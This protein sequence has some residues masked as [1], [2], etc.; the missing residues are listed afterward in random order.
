MFHSLHPNLKIRISINFIQKLTQTAIFPFM[1]IYF[2]QQ[3]GVTLAGVLI[4]TTTVLSFIGSLYGG[5]WADRYGRKRVLVS[6]ERLGFLSL[7]GM[8]ICNSTFLSDPTLTFVF[9]LM[10]NIVN[11]IVT[12]A[13]EAILIDDSTTDNRKFLYALS[14]WT[15]NISIVVGSI[16]G[17]FL[18]QA[19]LFDLLIGA[20]LASLACMLMIR[21][22]LNDTYR[23]KPSTTPLSWRG[24]CHGYAI[25]FRDRLFTIY[26]I[27]GVLTLSLELQLTHYLAIHFVDTFTTPQ[28]LFGVSLDG[29]MLLGVLRSENTVLVLLFSFLVLKWTKPFNERSVLYTG[30]VL[31]SGGFALLLVSGSVV[32]MLIGTLVFTLG[33]LLYVPIHQALLIGAVS[34][35]LYGLIPPLLM[36]VVYI[37]FGATAIWLYQKVYRSLF[38]QS[39]ESE[40]VG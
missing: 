2:A 12:P 13:N 39:M 30:V 35:S 14:Y 29:T 1:T 21:M 5:A 23:P 40:Q 32:V 8:A 11:G 22:R 17:G 10:N 7:G 27:A 4:V 31:F 37:T 3:F 33:E 36:A 24:L 9:F 25:V 6:G 16:V 15:L 38:V 28:S 34:V 18:F 26:L 19:H 20:A